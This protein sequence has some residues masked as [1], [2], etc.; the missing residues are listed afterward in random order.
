MISRLKQIFDDAVSQLEQAGDEAVQE[1]AE[2]R[3]AA[4]LLIEMSRA[5]HEVSAAERALI[6]RALEEV[7]AL[8]EQEVRELLDAAE[9]DAD[10]AT[11]L[12]EFT[13][14]LNQRLDHERKVHVV[15][16]LW[17]VAYA[18]GELEKHEAHLVR[19]VA[20]LLHLRHREYI[21][22]KLRA[23]GGDEG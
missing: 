20:D 6:A 5:D 23:Q 18:D 7:F 1:H 14:V 9:A 8:P 16:Q 13:S 22:G 21:G 3:A 10:D 4:A 17:R 19:K 2:R 15:D 12:Y 11:S